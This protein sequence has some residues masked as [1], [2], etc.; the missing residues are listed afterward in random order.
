MTNSFVHWA[1]IAQI[2]VAHNYI[3]SVDLNTYNK[4]KSEKEQKKRLK[5]FDSNP[6]T[7]RLTNSCIQPYISNAPVNERQRKEYEKEKKREEEVKKK[8]T[9]SVETK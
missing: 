6:N 4:E 1:D 7:H 9:T 2:L 5:C 8:D 3:P